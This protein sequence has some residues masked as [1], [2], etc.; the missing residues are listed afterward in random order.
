MFSF[1]KITMKCILHYLVCDFFHN[2]L[3][4]RRPNTVKQNL[5]T[6]E[7]TAFLSTRVTLKFSLSLVAQVHIK[8]VWRLQRENRKCTPAWHKLKKKPLSR[9]GLFS[10]CAM[11]GYTFR[12]LAAIEA[13]L[14]KILVYKYRILFQQTSKSARRHSV[15]N[16]VEV[17]MHF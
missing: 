2:T 12:F 13:K 9:K 1:K 17:F 10:A 15:V 4:Y 14:C 16:I 5:F 3:N 11:L 8:G 6:T 7:L